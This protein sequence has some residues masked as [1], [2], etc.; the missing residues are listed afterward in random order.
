MIT[1]A[2]NLRYVLQIV[3]LQNVVFELEAITEGDTQ[4]GQHITPPSFIVEDV[5]SPTQPL[6]ED[7]TSPKQPLAG[8]VTSPVVPLSVNVT[9]QNQGH[10]P[11]TVDEHSTTETVTQSHGELG[12]TEGTPSLITLL[13]GD[14]KCTQTSE[15]PLDSDSFE[16]GTTQNLQS[17]S[18]VEAVR[19]TFDTR[20][21]RGVRAAMQTKT[22]QTTPSTSQT[23]PSTSQTTPSTSQTTPSDVNVLKAARSMARIQDSSQ[24][25]KT[26]KKLLRGQMKLIAEWGQIAFLCSPL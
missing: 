18:A 1:H 11:L 25:S 10:T 17:Q 3:C 14:V 26:C 13:S 8:N 15:V 24:S 16:K 20:K 2:F 4:K 5:T 22:S 23:T 9:K 7:V 12:V 6:V 21:R 19:D